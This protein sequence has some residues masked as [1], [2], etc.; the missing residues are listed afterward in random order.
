MQNILL[1]GLL[2]RHLVALSEEC[3]VC[4]P[5]QLQYMFSTIS[6]E[7]LQYLRA[8]HGKPCVQ[9]KLEKLVHVLYL[10]EYL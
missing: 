3:N 6:V 9:I 8:E 1:L 10:G 4:G 5:L 7:M 2:Q